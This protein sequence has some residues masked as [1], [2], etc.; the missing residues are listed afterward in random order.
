MTRTTVVLAL[1]V[2]IA[3]AG[4]AGATQQICVYRSPEQWM[5]REKVEATARGMGYTKFFIQP[6]GGCWGIYATT[7][8]GARTEILLDPMTGDIVRQ[9]RT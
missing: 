5:P 6:D 9:G 2:L 4:A 1:G 3:G 8:D 7:P